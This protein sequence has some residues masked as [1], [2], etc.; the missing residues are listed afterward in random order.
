VFLPEL[1]AHREAGQLPI[2]RFT[3]TYPFADINQAIDDA[4]HGKCVKAVLVF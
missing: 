3:K 1:I 4:H 2:D